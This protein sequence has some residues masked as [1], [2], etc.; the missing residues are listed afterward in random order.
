MKE[1]RRKIKAVVIVSSTLANPVKQIQVV[2]NYDKMFEVVEPM[3]G[4]TI[5]PWHRRVIQYKL[6]ANETVKLI[7]E[8]GNVLYLKREDM[9]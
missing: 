6:T 9:K 8:P 5:R 3:L 4:K 1:R 7:I 2:G